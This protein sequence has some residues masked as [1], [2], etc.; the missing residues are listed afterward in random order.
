MSLPAL[1]SGLS[2]IASGYDALICDVWGVVHEGTAP[3]LAATD[4]LEKFRKTRGPVVLLS[5]A[6]RPTES[7]EAQFAQLG[8]P[9]CYDAIVTSGGAARDDL[10]RRAAKG[11]LAMMHL[12]PE[13]DGGL[14]E[15][16]DIERV[17]AARAEVVLCSGLFDDET[18]TPA[19]YVA[20]LAGLKARGLTML[21]ANPDQVVQRGG[22]LV[23]C[24]GALA[25]SYQAMGGEVVYYGKPH[26][27]I[28]NAALAATG[29]PAGRVLAIG[30][31]LETDIRGANG[32]G[33]DVLFIADGIHGEHVEPFT[34][35]H[36][37]KLFA[38][39][40]VHAPMAMRALTW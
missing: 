8:V 13:R 12:G 27:P 21:C 23:Y 11:P 5:N 30:D 9:R 18:E 16:L 28:Y 10:A 15:G 31:G 3:Y 34:P 7:I 2:A 38:E 39:Y 17:D 20:T 6:P 25:R 40:G 24:A 22:K 37:A 36:L 19:D 4:A 35:E 14:Y 26:A 29:C 32:V 1:L 33:L